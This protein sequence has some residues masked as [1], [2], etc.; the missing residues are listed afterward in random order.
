MS[1]LLAIATA[2]LAATPLEQ[3]QQAE[4][5]RVRAEVADQ[6]QLTTY[7]L[8][9]ELVY[10]W[11]QDPV[12]A[13]PTPVVLAGVT[14]PVGLG[15]GLE[16]LVENHLNDVI[17]HHPTTNVE[18]VH[19][20]TCTAVLVHSGPEGTVV[21]RGIDDPDALAKIGGVTG[22]HAL[23]VDIEAEGAWLVL[24][25]RITRLTPDLP[26]VW[27]HTISTSADTPALLRDSEHLKSAEEARQEYLDI[28]RGR[29]PISVPLRFAVRTYANP[30][31]GIGVP[32]PPFL[33]LESG[34]DL[35][36]TEAR[37]WTASIVLG[38][39]FI[40][41]AYQGVLAQAR[42]NRLVTGRARSLTRP[43]LYLF[44]GGAA[45][46]VWGPATAS[47][48]RKVPSADD[49]LAAATGDGP[50][51]AFG[52]LQLGLDLRIDRIGLS[53]FLEYMPDL[54]NSNN[55]GSYVRIGSVEAG[56][57]GTEV[58]FWF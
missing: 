21:S 28:L 46:G 23:F 14:V 53:T 48:Q 42:V 56:S 43:D 27:S 49:I 19:C 16:A 9:D 2:A 31:N 47:F 52:T 29:G 26:I 37:A 3:A 41:E 33:W 32:P 18:L 45:I 38:Y 50:R 54:V 6:V 58:T 25:A 11:T 17:Q 4:L 22:K 7:D 13:A 36:T 20:P 5:D 30:N 15:T 44:A 12:F 51:T 39:S 8:V 57:L 10:G 40:P 35:G 24:R 1:A 55:L 34:V